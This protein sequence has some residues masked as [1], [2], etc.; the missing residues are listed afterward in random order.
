MTRQQFTYFLQWAVIS[1]ISKDED[2]HLNSH[3]DFFYLTSKYNHI[4]PQACVYLINLFVS[5]P[6][7]ACKGHILTRKC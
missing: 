6:A 3:E 1:S 2:D 5:Q 7:C 4:S